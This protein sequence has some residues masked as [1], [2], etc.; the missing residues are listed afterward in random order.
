MGIEYA[1]QW[2]K[3]NWRE[4]GRGRGREREREKEREG[5]REREGEREGERE[6]ERTTLITEKIKRNNSQELD[7]REVYNNNN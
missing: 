2:N 4:R 5:G 1:P 3:N 7:S 6:R